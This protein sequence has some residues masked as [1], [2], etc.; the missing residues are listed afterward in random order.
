MLIL[1]RRPTESL[2]IA[3]NITVT[4][5]AINGNQVRLGIEAPKDVV[6]DRA[7]VHARKQVE[8]RTSAEPRKSK[9]QAARMWLNSIPGG[10]IQLAT[11]APNRHGALVRY[12][13]TTSPLALPE[14]HAT[15]SA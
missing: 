13:P 5:L 3:E 6:I 14:P 11:N 9:P 4:I 15:P 12:I 10:G 7:E 2:V 1:S 8:Y